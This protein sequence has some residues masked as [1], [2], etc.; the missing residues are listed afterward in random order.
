MPY[1]SPRTTIKKDY[2]IVEFDAP[3]ADARSFFFELSGNTLYIKGRYLGDGVGVS[4]SLYSRGGGRI[5]ATYD[6][7]VP[8]T[9]DTRYI[10][11]TYNDD[12]L[13]FSFRRADEY[14]DQRFKIYLR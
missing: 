10:E 8:V 4:F 6:I 2:F 9:D 3:E 12:V 1:R 7:P 13:R 11:A 14:P 5:D